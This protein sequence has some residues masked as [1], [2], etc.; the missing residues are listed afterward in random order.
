MV[1][2]IYSI[3]GV[4]VNMDVHIDV[5][6][7]VGMAEAGRRSLSTREGY[8]AAYYGLLPHLSLREDSHFT[9]SHTDT[10]TDAHAHICSR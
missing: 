9:S 3:E 2:G 5:D 7:G 8:T 4:D 6:V 1:G 10:D